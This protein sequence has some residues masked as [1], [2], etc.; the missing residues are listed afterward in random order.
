MTK[1]INLFGGPS[2]GKS[3]IAA[4]LYY[5]LKMMHKEVEL[6]LEYVRDLIYEEQ[7]K[8][9]NNQPYIFGQQLHR[10]TRLIDKVE[11]IIT[12]SPLLL[13]VLYCP[14][15]VPS[16]FKMAVTDIFKQFTNY[17]YLIVRAFKYVP[18]SRLHTEAQAL[19]IDDDIK[20]MLKFNKIEYTEMAGTESGLLDI[21]KR[22]T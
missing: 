20:H 19:S 10:L 12:D 15:S 21:L 17:N 5:K 6:S 14:D 13:S 8:T 1:I 11:Y 4:G 22:I 3:T 2:C 7:H 9:I 18:T 16:S